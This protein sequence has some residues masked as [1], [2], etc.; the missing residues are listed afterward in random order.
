MR[1]Q[2]GASVVVAAGAG[3]LTWWAGEGGGLALTGVLAALGGVLVA[4]TAQVSGYQ[5]AHL[6]AAL[7]AQFGGM[8]LK[9]LAILGAIAIG[10]AVDVPDTPLGLGVIVLILAQASAGAF[11]AH[12]SRVLTVDPPPSPP[13]TNG[14]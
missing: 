2:L 6:Q 12:R 3:G 9:G 13:S 14:T 7:P 1:A 5:L 11:G 10:L 4:I 8:G